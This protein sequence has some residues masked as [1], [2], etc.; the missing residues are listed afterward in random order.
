MNAEK[1]LDDDGVRVR[2]IAIAILFSFKPGQNPL[3]TLEDKRRDL[4]T[5]SMASIR[6]RTNKQ[7][8]VRWL[9]RNLRQEGG[10]LM[11]RGDKVKYSDKQKRRAEH[12]EDS[13]EDRGG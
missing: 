6:L 1:V 10:L 5:T 2:Y 8:E 7:K 12:I 4:L 9:H 11:P 3:C 13:Y